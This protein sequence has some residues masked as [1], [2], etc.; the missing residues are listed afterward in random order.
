MKPTSFAYHMTTYFFKYL[1]GKAGI[2]RN[3]ILSYRDT[4]SLLLRFCSE[5]KVMTNVSPPFFRHSKAMHLLQSGVNLVYIRDV[6]RPRHH[7]NY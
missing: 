2:R 6:I 1:P 7:Q 5:D 4:F 3:T